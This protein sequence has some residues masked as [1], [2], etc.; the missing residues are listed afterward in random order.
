MVCVGSARVSR[1]GFGLRRNELSQ[2]LHRR[3]KVVPQ[4][5]YAM[6]G[7]PS[8][9]TRRMHCPIYCNPGRGR[10]VGR[11]LGVGVILDA[12][13]GV[14]VAVGV[15]VAVG[16]GLGVGVGVAATGTIA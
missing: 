5:K 13:V 3:S 12:A 16:V 6:A 15:A 7:K 1:A 9:H 14:G 10:G 2:Y 11:G 4:E 8:K